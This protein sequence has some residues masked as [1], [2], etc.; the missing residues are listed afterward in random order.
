MVSIARAL[1]RYINRFSFFF[2]F[3]GKV[4]ICP[5][6]MPGFTVYP[7][8]HVLKPP[9][10][11]L[12][13]YLHQRKLIIVINPVCVPQLDTGHLEGDGL[14]R[15]QTRRAGL[16]RVGDFTRFSKSCGTFRY[17]VYITI[18]IGYHV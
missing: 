12:K 13:S 1:C 6:D 7:I 10:L 14:R 16:M 9:P 5:D 18:S 3:S 17:A 4:V 8:V 11:T 15:C 2:I